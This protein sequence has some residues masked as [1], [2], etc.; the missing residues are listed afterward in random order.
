MSRTNLIFAD[1]L[2][3]IVSLMIYNT[4]GLKKYPVILAPLLI[5][6]FASCAIRHITYFNMTRKIY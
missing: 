2:F 6:A 4:D 3:I 5:I 1:T